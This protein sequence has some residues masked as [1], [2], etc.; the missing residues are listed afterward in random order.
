MGN[1]YSPSFMRKL[2]YGDKIMLFGYSLKV[3]KLK[4]LCLYLH[5][6]LL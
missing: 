1:I 5:V 4:G 3:E 2:L 6:W